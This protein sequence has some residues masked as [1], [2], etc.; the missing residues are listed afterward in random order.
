[1]RHLARI[2]LSAITFV[3]VAPSSA[4]MGPPGAGGPIVMGSGP[5]GGPPPFLSRV[6][7][8]KLVMEHQQE[9]GL[10]PAQAEA[11]KKAM[12]ETQKQLLD[13]QWRLDAE[14]EALDKLLATDHVDE[15]AVLA[16]LEQVTGI[17]QQVKKVNFALL[18]RIKNQLTSEQQAKLRS[19]RPTRHGG[20]F[21]GPPPPPE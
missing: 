14:S 3:W 1:M 10:T 17:E 16:K 19:L 20:G 5:P 13:I 2:A 12:N 7:V 9:I 8:P 18:V 15:A 6:F 4:Q 21:G 11:I